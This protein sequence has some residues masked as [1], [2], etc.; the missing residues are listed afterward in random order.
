MKK[1][2]IVVSTALFA[3][4]S[5]SC[6]LSLMV[7]FMGGGQAGPDLRG[8][9]LLQAWAIPLEIL[10]IGFVTALFVTASGLR[11]GLKRLWVAMPQW[12]VFGFVLLNSLFLLGELAVFIAARA[13]G[14]AISLSE[15][16]PLIS[17]FLSSLAVLALSA[18]AHD[19]QERAFAGRWAP[20]HD[21]KREWPEDF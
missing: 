14:G 6:L 20:P 4:I 21:E 3:A 8:L 18:W 1:P 13:T 5:L 9:M 17:L 12:L 7:I 15:Q 19:G 11:G 2:I 10:V 16:V